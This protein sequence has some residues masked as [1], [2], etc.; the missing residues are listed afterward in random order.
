M[1]PSGPQ[2]FL[3]QL[4]V[5][6]TLA[7]ALHGFAPRLRHALS[8]LAGR[9]SDRPLA[10]FAVL[11]GLS[12]FAYL[13]LAMIYTPWDWTYLGPFSFQLSRPLHYLVYFFAAFTIGSYGCDRS[14]LRTDGPIARHCFAWLAGTV[15]CF[16]A[17]GGLTSLTLPDWNASPLLYRFAAALA[18]PPACATGVLAYLSIALRLLRA[19]HPVLDSLSANAYGIYLGHYVFVLW[20]QYA[21]IDATL[22]AFGKVIVVFV[23]ALALSWVTSAGTRRAGNAVARMIAKPAAKTTAK[24]TAKTVEALVGGSTAIPHSDA[25]AN[26]TR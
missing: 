19:R 24:T 3:W 1:W 25:I 21:L 26:H 4:F 5:L 6:S 7:A 16:A 20:L 14:V 10:F 12:A 13:P 18:F 15:T 11:T 17:W 23:V 22:N 2:W 9:T 8:D